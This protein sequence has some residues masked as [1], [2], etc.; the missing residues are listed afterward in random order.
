MTTPNE[1]STDKDMKTLTDSPKYEIFLVEDDKFLVNIYS[2]KFEH[3]GYKVTVA[4][5]GAE[6]LSKIVDGY[7]P[8]IML[9]DISMPV[10]NG[11]EFLAAIKKSNLLKDTVIIILTNQQS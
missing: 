9:C 8:D 5:N 1:K 7:T 11:Y 4:E 6:A 10:M 3:Y 2:V